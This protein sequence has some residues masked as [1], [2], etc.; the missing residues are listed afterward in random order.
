MEFREFCRKMP[1]A[2]RLDDEQ[3]CVGHCREEGEL[4]QKVDSELPHA[5]RVNEG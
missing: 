5:P 1:I 2:G 4:Q 3:N